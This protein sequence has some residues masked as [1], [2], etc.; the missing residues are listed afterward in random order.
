MDDALYQEFMET[1]S[2]PQDM[3]DKMKGQNLMRT[4]FFE[5]FKDFRV[6]LA[7]YV[8]ENVDEINFLSV[9]VGTEPVVL[10]KDVLKGTRAYVKNQGDTSCIL[11]TNGKTGYRLDSGE[12]IELFVNRPF[13][14]TTVSGVTDLGFAQY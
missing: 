5:F 2:T 12:R 11:T 10:F 14:A 4:F 9:T 1:M 7:E 8:R 13:I 6:Y 3:R